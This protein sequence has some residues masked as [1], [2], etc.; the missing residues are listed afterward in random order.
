M[1]LQRAGIS[2]VDNLL[3]AAFSAGGSILRRLLETPSYRQVTAAVHLADATFTSSW[4]DQ[5]ARQPPAIE[6]FVQYGVDVVNGLGDKLLVATASPSPNKTWA[7]GIE[8]LAAIRKEIEARTG[9]SFVERAD[10][11]GV[12]PAP[13]VVHQLGN[14][15][16][17]SY[18]AEPLGHGHTAI[19]SQIWQRIITPWMAKGTG[20]RCGGRSRQAHRGP[21]PWSMW[22]FSPRRP[23]A[24]SG[25]CET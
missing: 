16:F 5:A 22:Y 13:S 7:T 23:R 18:P 8:N 1:L 15:L 14:V 2:A 17:A 20:H 21:S 19:A 4:L 11:F 12:D 3:L 6:G 10:F 9:Q 25:W 24:A